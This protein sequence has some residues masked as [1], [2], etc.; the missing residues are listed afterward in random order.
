[1]AFR[2]SSFKQGISDF[3]ANSSPES[4]DYSCEESWVPVQNHCVPVQKAVSP[5]L[6]MRG[7][8]CSQ[9]VNLKTDSKTL[10]YSILTLKHSLQEGYKKYALLNN[11]H[12][13]CHS[14][15][16]NRN[17]FYK[18]TCSYRSTSAFYGMHAMNYFASLGIFMC[19]ACMMQR[20]QN[21]W[22]W[23]FSI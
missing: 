1:M 12:N 23:N 4:R 9:T 11:S 3:F 21:N 8:L 6:K 2:L 17:Y 18:N 5:K 22:V 16:T 10:Y 7:P 15:Y 13:N 14:N 20:W 19:Q